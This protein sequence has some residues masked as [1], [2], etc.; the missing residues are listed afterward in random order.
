MMKYNTYLFFTNGDK[1]YRYN[2]L[3]GINS[4]MGPGNTP[5]LSLSEL[6]YGP[7]AKDHLH[8][9]FSFRANF[10]AGCIA[11]RK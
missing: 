2:L 7:E 10:I 4:N 8:V 6:G 3:N 11:L 5:I 1:L 9:C